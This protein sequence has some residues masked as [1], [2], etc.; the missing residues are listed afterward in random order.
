MNKRDQDPYPC[1]NYLLVKGNM[2]K[3]EKDCGGET[4]CRGGQGG[5][6]RE[7]LQ[8]FIGYSSFIEKKHLRKDLK[9]VK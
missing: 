4:K 7:Q 2:L 9:N 5:L 1:N 8:L 6:R 3:D